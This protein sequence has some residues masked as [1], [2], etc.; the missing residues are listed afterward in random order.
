VGYY[1]TTAVNT[2]GFLLV[3]YITAQFALLAN[4]LKYATENVL[5]LTFKAEVTPAFRSKY[6]CVC[7]CH[8]V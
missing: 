4:T 1:I 6:V 2:F 7:V 3:I 8:Y 5:E